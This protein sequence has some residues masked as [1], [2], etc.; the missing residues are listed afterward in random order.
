VT[1]ADNVLGHLITIG[2][3]QSGYNINFGKVPVGETGT[4][5]LSVV[6]VGSY[7]DQSGGELLYG[8][9]Q[10]SFNPN[11]SP[12]Q[13]TGYGGPMIS[14]LKFTFTPTAV[15]TQ[16][17]QLIGY[18]DDFNR[19]HDGYYSGVIFNLTGTGVA[20]SGEAGFSLTT[21]PSPVF[22]EPLTFTVK[23]FNPDRSLNT[24]FN[25]IVSIA[26]SGPLYAGIAPVSGTLTA[27][28]VK[29]VGSF[30]FTPP[31][32]GIFAFT[33]SSGSV[34]TPTDITIGAA[35]TSVQASGSFIAGTTG[36][37]LSLSVTVKAQYAV[38]PGLIVA[39]LDRNILFI[40]LSLV[41]GQATYTSGPL[42]QLSAGN[43]TLAVEFIGDGDNFGGSS[44]TISIPYNPG[45]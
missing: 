2:G 23:A 39:T 32:I 27:T 6:P 8:Y 11:F 3:G 24:S 37:E 28:L 26:C 22:G 13:P 10:S 30:S 38:V 14:E 20:A 7:P 15:G 33:A 44:T 19:N 18:D 5:E 4:Y 25:G 35:P 21:V 16:S 41:N 36:P 17:T 45:P 34:S 1:V 9:E 43:H 31:D 29:G 42:T 40:E 12:N